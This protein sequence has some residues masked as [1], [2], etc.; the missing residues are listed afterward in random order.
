[1]SKGF[2]WLPL[3]G[4]VAGFS[5]TVLAQDLPQGQPQYRP[6]VPAISQPETC[7]KLGTNKGEIVLVLDRRGAPVSSQNFM[8]YVDEKYYDGTIFHRVIGN[9]MIQGGGFDKEFAQKETNKPIPNESNNG[10]KNLRGTIA[11]ARTSSPHSATSQFF[12][13]TVDNPGLDYGARG[14]NSWGYA[15]FGKVV[16]GMEVVDQISQVRTGRMRQHRDVPAELVMIMS[17]TSFT[18]VKKT[19][20]AP[21]QQTPNQQVQ[22]K[23]A[24]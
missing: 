2:K 21:N 11:M 3:L 9:F 12:I 4:L 22:Q 13:N 20:P 17:A 5:S 7:V 1:M 19:V 14:A 6:V 24:Q 18:C 10:Q 16:S 8:S 23:P 15:V